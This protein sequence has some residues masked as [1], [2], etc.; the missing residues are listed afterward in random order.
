MKKIAFYP[1]SFDPITLGHEDIIRRATKLF[2]LV[3]VGVVASHHDKRSL[4]SK[5]ERITLARNVFTGKEGVEVV[6]FSGLSV[7]VAKQYE[8]SVILR[9]IRGGTDIDYEFNMASMNHQ[10]APDIETVFLHSAVEYR[11]IRSSLIK[12]I[13]R[14]G[15]DISA[16]VSPR[17][18]DAML[19]K[20]KGN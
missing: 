5:A 1:G 2:D 6:S 17:V 16:F 9:G 19:S 4:F 8:A 11:A 14:N 12:D 7:D 3:V 10:L 20:M 15:G 18:K 13:A